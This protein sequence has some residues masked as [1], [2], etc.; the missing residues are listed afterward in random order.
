MEWCSV[1]HNIKHAYRIGLRKIYI[2]N[3]NKNS[4]LN[5]VK[6]SEI[7]ELYLAGQMSSKEIGSMYGVAQSTVTD[8]AKGKTWGGKKLSI[9]E[10]E[11][12]SQSNNIITVKDLVTFLNK[13]YG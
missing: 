6:A 3:G 13:H 12:I 2:G 7:K 1:H 8:I 10:I 9:S 11:S 5:S 4:K